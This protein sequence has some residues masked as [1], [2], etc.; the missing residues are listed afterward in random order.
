M[1]R[2]IRLKDKCAHDVRK[3]ESSKINSAG[4]QL[5]QP[6]DVELPILIPVYS[7]RTIIL[8]IVAA[9]TN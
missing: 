9:R 4:S 6:M 8:T 5:C 2:L 3:F 1:S 7:S